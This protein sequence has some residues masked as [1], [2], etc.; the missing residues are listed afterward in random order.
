ML[1]RPKVAPTA[2]CALV[3]AAAFAGA[4]QTRPQP[5]FDLARLA[6]IDGVVSEAMAAHQL[7]GAVVVVG[8]GDTVVLRKAYGRRAI[9]PQPEPMTLDTIFDI[10]SLTKVVATTPAV[11]ML[12][13][14]GRIRLTDPVATFIPEF[15]KYGKDRV[16]VRDL[17]T[18]MSGLRPDLDLAEPWVGHDDAIRLAAEEVLTDP[19]G[20]RFVYSDINYLLL[21]EIV[22][23]VSKQP[24]QEFVRDRLFAPLG[25]RETMFTPSA[26]LVP[27]I[28]PTQPCTPDGWPCE[29]P[30]MTMLRGVVHDPTARRMGG[31]AGHAGLFSTVGGP[32]DLC[33]HAAR[34]RRGGR[35]ARAGA[36][37]GRAHDV[38]G[39]AGR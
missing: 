38:A 15:G 13:E 7:P 1:G 39:D 28:A 37:D 35:R 19:P 24:L 11:M 16:T 2:V 31:V 23:R 27:R 34:R 20:R 10:A 32:D 6:R 22:S 33:A 21:G 30:G 5:A 17:L 4:A 18:H 3:A 25:M 26:A 14:D 36:A 12:V 8:R 29:G 9:E